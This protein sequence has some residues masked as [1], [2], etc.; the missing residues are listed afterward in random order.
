MADK[1]ETGPTTNR[2]EFVHPAN[3]SDEPILHDERSFESRLEI[4]R[5]L[6]LDLIDASRLALT[7]KALIVGWT[8]AEACDLTLTL[9]ETIFPIIASAID[10][11]FTYLKDNGLSFI[12]AYRKYSNLYLILM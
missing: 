8:Q 3:S 6:Y 5:K 10:E 12:V 1:T 9:K 2:D 4:H 11:I 7:K